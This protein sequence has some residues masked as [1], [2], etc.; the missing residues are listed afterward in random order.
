MKMSEYYRE[1]EAEALREARYY[2]RVP[3]DLQKAE[4]AKQMRQWA[5]QYRKM[6][7][8]AEAEEKAEEEA[9]ARAKA[10][11]EATE[12]EGESTMKNTTRH[13]TTHSTEEAW[14]V[15]NEIIPC[16]YLHDSDRSRRAGYD[17]YFSTSDSVIAWISDLGDRLEVNLPDGSSVNVWI[18]EEGEIAEAEMN[19][20]IC[21][22]VQAELDAEAVTLA[23]PEQGCVWDEDGN[24]EKTVGQMRDEIATY[25]AGSEA[26]QRMSIEP[27]YT[28]EVCQR[29]TLVI[30]GDYGTEDEKAVFEAI[31]QGSPGILF[32]LLTR[33]AE[34]HGIIWGGIF[35]CKADHYDHG[36]PEDGKKGHYCVDGFITGSIGEEMAFCANCAD[37]LSKRHEEHSLTA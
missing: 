6:A 3:E 11:A 36:E 16:D 4:G 33:Y 9:E 12:K 26:V 37:L 1:R 27:L 10:E 32:D 22:A 29:V 24:V 15:A 31:R 21:K 19:D 23:E 14:S 17:I 35:G 5:A 28:P 30:D 7:E 2:E 25:K 8:E 18:E 34:T 20:A 13:I